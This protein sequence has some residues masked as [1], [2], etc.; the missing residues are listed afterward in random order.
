MLGKQLQ[1]VSF[2]KKVFLMKQG[3]VEKYYW[4]K[5]GSEGALLFSLIDPDKSLLE[6]GVEVAKKSEEAGA[7]AILIGGSVGAQGAVLDDTVKLIKQAISLPVVIFPGNISGITK[8]ADAIYF[9]HLLNSRDVYWL[10]TAQI[11]AAPVVARLGIEAI[12]TTY[13]V[14]EPGQAVGWVGNANLLPRDRPDLA[15]ACALAAKYSG[16]R[17]LIAD[18]GS[19]APSPTPTKLVSSIAKACDHDLLFFSAGGVKTPRQATEAIEAGA[20]GIQVGTAFE[21]PGDLVKKVSAMRAAVKKAGKK[22][23]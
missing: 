20:H 3:K 9:M 23:V 13:L 15:A 1:A 16:S 11:Q 14:V 7:D 10:S 2:E 6:K 12:P 19:G 22:R 21:S 17:V 5:I 4:E 8:Y 18:S